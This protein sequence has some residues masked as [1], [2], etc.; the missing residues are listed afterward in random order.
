[1]IWDV[2]RSTTS[3][4]QD[5]LKDKGKDNGKWIIS[6][7]T[8]STFMT[9]KDYVVQFK[10]MGP[11]RYRKKQHPYRRQDEPLISVY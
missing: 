3:T 9:P 1:M 6:R 5:Y 4:Y 2:S 8:D 11:S 7:Y 10:R